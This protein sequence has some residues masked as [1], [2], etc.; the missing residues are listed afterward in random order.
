MVVNDTN[1]GP[2]VRCKNGYTDSRYLRGRRGRIAFCSVQ[3]INNRL[4]LG[5][6][7]P[8]LLGP[9]QAEVV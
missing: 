6:Q 9:R 1:G 4:H 2:V 3:A 7:E 8:R 5:H